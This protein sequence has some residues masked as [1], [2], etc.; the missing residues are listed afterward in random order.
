MRY[1]KISAEF[2]PYMCYFAT[3]PD[4]F[5]GSNNFV[6]KFSNNKCQFET[7]Q[8]S[9]LIAHIKWHLNINPFKCAFCPV[10]FPNLKSLRHHLSRSHK[11]RRPKKNGLACPFD[12]CT[13][14]LEK[15]SLGPMLVHIKEIH[16]FIEKIQTF[17]SSISVS[18]ASSS[19]INKRKFDKNCRSLLPTKKL[20]NSKKNCE[21]EKYS[22]SF[23]NCNFESHSSTQVKAHEFR[24]HRGG[25]NFQCPHCDES[26]LDSKIELNQHLIDV[27]GISQYKCEIDDCDGFFLN[28]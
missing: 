17:N 14:R 26:N 11:R 1:H 10:R 22:C 23:K 6:C 4:Y 3:V 16:Q 15:P 24:R 27:H 18:L 19:S 8:S 2:I 25:V 28:R 21:N 20:R 5:E 7:K 9:D 12:N 13:F